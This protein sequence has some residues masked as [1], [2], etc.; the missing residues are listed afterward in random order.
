MQYVAQREASRLS[1]E[2]FNPLC[3]PRFVIPH[4]ARLDLVPSAVWGDIGLPPETYPCPQI[5]LPAPGAQENLAVRGRSL[6]PWSFCG[7][8]CC[9]TFG[10]GWNSRTGGEPGR[11]ALR[12]CRRAREPL[13]RLS[14]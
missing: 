10:G 9:V 5:I 3:D 6:L 12:F 8:A 7:I 4:L 11:V 2:D 14:R 1:Q 13:W